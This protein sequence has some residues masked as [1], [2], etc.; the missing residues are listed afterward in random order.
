M[1]LIFKNN[2]K[3]NDS[4]IEGIINSKKL[5]KNKT[6]HNVP[7]M[8]DKMYLKSSFSIDDL[9][10]LN[11]RKLNLWLKFRK[12]YKLKIN[13]TATQMYFHFVK[14]FHMNNKCF[15]TN[16]CYLAA[17][18]NCFELFKLLEQNMSNVCYVLS[19]LNA[20]EGKSIKIL[21]YIYE[22]YRFTQKIWIKPL[23]GL[24]VI[25][26]KYVINPN[27]AQENTDWSVLYYANISNQNDI[28]NNIIKN[29]LLY[30]GCPLNEKLSFEQ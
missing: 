19:C 4:L 8:Y 22:K 7:F 23:R 3:I 13:K 18:Y 17:E 26:N 16:L 1:L 30:I 21:K 25:N 29:F 9:Q 15:N 28:H 24:T 20:I 27:N 6:H 2:Y 10:Y 5:I 11:K 12:Y 14:I